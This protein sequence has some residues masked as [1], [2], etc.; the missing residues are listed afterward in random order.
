MDTSR[1][2]ALPD[3]EFKPEVPS[4]AEKMNILEHIR[5]QW[6][7]VSDNIL[8]APDANAPRELQ[9]ID[10]RCPLCKHIQHLGP[11]GVTGQCEKCKLYYK[12]TAAKANCWLWIWRGPERIDLSPE[13]PVAFRPCATCIIPTT[14]QKKGCQQS[15]RQ[16][17]Q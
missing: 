11:P 8:G 4:F 10:L 15:T 7:P 14:C 16:V 5:Y 2:K 9:A 6:H 17:A 13:T 3:P 1:N 12:Y